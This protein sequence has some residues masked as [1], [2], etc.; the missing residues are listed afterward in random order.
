MITED[1]VGCVQNCHRGAATRIGLGKVAAH[2][3]I[4]LS[5]LTN[6]DGYEDEV[7]VEGANVLY[8]EE[9]EL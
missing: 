4:V 9:L 7:R 3:P 6:R 2:E 1:S 8:P 5:V